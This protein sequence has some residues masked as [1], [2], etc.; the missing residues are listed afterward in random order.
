[1]PSRARVLKVAVSVAVF[2]HLQ[3]RTNAFSS[4]QC[5][6]PSVGRPFPLT[7]TQKQSPRPK[8]LSSQS[9][10]VRTTIWAK[11]DD[12]GSPSEEK[13]EANNNTSNDPKVSVTALESDLSFPSG[14]NG[15]ELSSDTDIARFEKPKKRLGWKRRFRAALPGA[16]PDSTPGI[17]RLVLTTAIPSMLNLAVVPLVNSVD[18]F[19]V[20]RMGI[21]LALAGQAA[22]NQAFFTVYFLVAFL[23][24]LTAPLVAS[25]VGSGN[26]EEARQRINES[27]F[28]CNVFG[29]M[30]TI[31]LVGFPQRA[32][33]MVLPAGAPAFAYATPYMRF[34]G[35]SMIPALLSATGFAAYRGLLDTV[36][37]LK[38][39]LG[40]NILNLVLDPLLIFGTPLRVVGAAL[41]TAF[42]ETA[43]GLVYLRL[44]M[45]KGFVTLRGLFKPPSWA[46]LLPL[47]QGG[48]S[49]LGRQLVLNVGILAAARRAQSLDPSGGVAAAAYGIVMQMYSVGIVVHVALQ[50]TAAALVP[51]TLTK[52]GPADARKVADRLFVWSTLIG[53]L[54]GVT[55]VLALPW[56]VPIFSTLPAVREAVRTPAMITSV[57]HILNGPVFCGEGVLLGLGNFSHLLWITAAG[58]GTLLASLSMPWAQSLNGI[59]IG[60]VVFTIVQAL[61]VVV[62]YLKIGSL[63]VGRDEPNNGN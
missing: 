22:A 23:P 6:V 9:R 29:L 62:H 3:P 46:S 48:V 10:N 49:V 15:E 26:Q 31:F 50:G 21:A 39:S 41:A 36:T 54:M 25:A 7:R 51:S 18:T 24:T 16:H 35:L 56:L 17:D 55:Q 19:W 47:L 59:L 11:D 1:M 8:I 12:D 20:G 52:S 14:I 61:A 4:R 53:L 63:A 5:L 57:L 34:R 33:D 43:S 27:L 37:P 42:S 40:T 38:V 32:L 44:L 30:G 60:Y 13:P 58:I 2:L 28:L 45:K